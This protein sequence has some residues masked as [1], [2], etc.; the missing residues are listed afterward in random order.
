MKLSKNVVMAV[1]VCSAV[2]CILLTVVIFFF[3]SRYSYE[4]NATRLAKKALEFVC[5]VPS[6]VE[7]VSI[8]EPIPFKGKRVMTDRE[9]DSISESINKI[10]NAIM[11]GYMSEDNPESLEIFSRQM[12]AVAALAS[13]PSLKEDSDEING[14]KVIIDFKARSA[15][16]QP[17]HSKLWVILDKDCKVVIN[18]IE[19]P[20]L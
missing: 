2:W 1:A 17:Y 19:I 12:N 4:G 7:I 13:I 3:H 9:M 20:V 10:S 16:G 6:S 14:Y 11:T 18:S 5:E 15:N 8:S